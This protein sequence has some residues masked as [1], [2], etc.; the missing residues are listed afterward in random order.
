MKP[1]EHQQY[2]PPQQPPAQQPPAQQ[3]SQVQQ[4]GGFQI[5]GI[6]A[7]VVFG[8]MVLFFM[9]PMLF[10]SA[11][12]FVQLVVVPVLAIIGLWQVFTWIAWKH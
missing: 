11:F 10:G 9:L 12:V 3:H 1:N 5:A 4:I 7:L 8:L 6:A 2:T